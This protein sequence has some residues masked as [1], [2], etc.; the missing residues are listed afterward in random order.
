MP[1]N[2]V[3]RVGM[4]T[5]WTEP[6]SLC[7][8]FNRM[9]TDGNYEWIDPHGRRIR[10][11]A[12]DPEP[13]Y[14]VVINSPRPQDEP[15]IS[16]E[17]TIVFQM[18]PE[19]W[20]PRMRRQW[21]TWASPS[22]LGF[23]QVRDHRRYRNSCDWWLGLSQR[24]LVDAPLPPKTRPLA[25]CVSAK[26]SDPGHTRRLDFLRF[27]DRQ[28]IDIDIYGDSANGFLHGRGPTPSNN[29][30]PAIL[31]YEYYVD[32]E[33][34]ASS[35]FFTEKIV[36]CLLAEVLCFYWGCPN[37]DAFFDPRAFVQLEMDD[38]EADLDRIRSA[39][40]TN[41]RATR[42]PYI[43]AE[44]RRFLEDYAFFP[45]LARILD[46][47]R[48]PHI[49][50]APARPAQEIASVIGGK[51]CGVFVEVSDRV[52]L[53]TESETLD[54]ERA[55]RWSGLC[56]E[57]DPARLP[58][59]R[60]LRDC[61]VVGDD[62]KSVLANELQRHAIRPLAIDWLNLA[63]RQ[64]STL[65][66][67]GGR[68]DLQRVRANVISFPRADVT[69]R[70]RCLDLLS[71]AGYEA[72]EGTLGTIPFSALRRGRGDIYGFYHLC[73]INTWRLV[74]DEQI[75]A[76]LS[77][78]L[79]AAS[80]RIFAVVVGPECDEA[81]ATLRRALGDQIEIVHRSEDTSPYE[82]PA[83]LFCRRFCSEIE[84]LAQGV[85]YVHSKGV[86]PQTYMNPNVSDWRRM[87]EHFVVTRWRECA[88]A[89]REHDVCG[90]NWRQ[91]P[92]PHFSG[93]FWWAAPR[94][95]AN[96][97]ESIGDSYLEPEAWLASNQPSV[98][99]LHQSEVGN[100]YLAPYPAEAYAD[101]R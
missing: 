17:R 38:F 47:E 56:L 93:N 68:I 62:S 32:A 60:S 67:P 15:L 3:I 69:E 13:D 8:L 45:T 7:E 21:G 81:I 22:P 97:P 88:L 14:W 27:L 84:P 9:T 36:D 71:Q 72:G 76:W 77:S 55:F 18:E 23:L 34:H 6:R 16:R 61:I 89:V 11:V 101:S 70:Q 63:V 10:M 90:V 44:K 24:Q 49:S 54:A 74:I 82:R 92:F 78:G 26:Y 42:L 94:Y 59:A 20:T 30:S 96:L 64:P 73:T 98:R 2:E 4:L 99:C 19:M 35:N 52:T 46:A 80:Q 50:N 58:A 51:R 79:A 75:N 1:V 29:K 37:L 87:M 39:I 31:P 91:D 5:N 53:P 85:W 57:A 86:S 100:H 25:A 43:Q 40:A 83:L 41:E 65:L 12:D 33:N 66:E 95:V 28:D 48:R